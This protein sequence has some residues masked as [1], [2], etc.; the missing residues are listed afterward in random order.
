MVD[1]AI[2]LAGASIV[3]S[4]MA[5]AIQALYGIAVEI[6]KYFDNHILDM[7]K[8]ENPTISRTG[9]VLEMAKYGFGLGYISSVVIVSVGQLLLGNFL[10]AITTVATAATVTNPI[11]MTCAA[12]GAI[13]YGWGALSDTERDE[14][15]D[16][17]SKGLNLGIELIKAMV[18]FV[19]DSTNG[20][21]NSKNLKDLKTYIVSAAAVFGKTLGDVTHKFADVVGD[22]FDVVKKKTGEAATKTS[23]IADE[24][25]TKGGKVIDKTT[26]MAGQTYDSVKKAG[27]KAATSTRKAITKLKSNATLSRTA[28]DEETAPSPPRPARTKGG[29]KSKGSVE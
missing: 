24:L 3:L 17:L 27:A 20:L 29:K 6:N 8:S 1:A 18:R 15:L 14:M 11:A 10:S 25:V 7:K 28:H 23:D 26:E 2:P 4:P 9:R 12:I 21:L 22:T 16:K 5:Q 19:I 13:Y